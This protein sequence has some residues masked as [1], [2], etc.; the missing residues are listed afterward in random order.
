MKL[1]GGAELSKKWAIEGPQA[2]QAH[3]NT[4]FNVLTPVAYVNN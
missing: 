4:S 1:N 2:P 3:P